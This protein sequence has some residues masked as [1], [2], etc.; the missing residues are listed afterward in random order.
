VGRL[1]GKVIVITGGGDGLGRTMATMFAAEGAAVALAARRRELLDETAALVTAAGGSALTVPADVTDEQ[2]VVDMVATTVDAFG[3]VD[4]LVNNAAQPGRDLHIW[5]QTLENWNATIAI[6]VT[7][8]MLCSRE[9]LR[10]SMLERRAGSIVNVSST[11]SWEGIPR[12][13]HYAVAKAGLRTLT[14]VV[15]KEVGEFGIRVN[16]LV[17]GG[18][19]TDL[20][21]NYWRRIADERGVTWEEIRDRGAQSLALRRVATTDEVAAAVLFLASDDASFISGVG[22]AVDGAKAAGV[23]PID[24]FRLDLEFLQA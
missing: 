22:L 8:A 12:K 3:R 13:S 19:Q 9:V 6:D 7:A 11:A 16:C 18:I 21:R 20:L 2:Q 15:A 5:E 14:K 23:M 10:Q 1:E 24:R 17:P 4:A